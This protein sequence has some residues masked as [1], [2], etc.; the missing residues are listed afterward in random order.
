[1]R[2][3]LNRKWIMSNN[4]CPRCKSP[5]I[6]TFEMA[7]LS[8]VSVNSTVGAGVVGDGI[9]VGAASGTS[10]TLLAQS[11]APPKEKSAI[12]FPLLIAWWIFGFLIV[13]ENEK[14]GGL[15][16]ATFIGLVVGPFAPFMT[17]K[18]LISFYW[19]AVIGIVLGGL[20]CFFA[21][22]WN[23]KHFP[24]LMRQ[25][26]SSWLCRRCGNKW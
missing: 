17:L 19:A 8:G 25:W 7:Y 6:Q 13:W 12:L 3:P 10:E 16:S 18:P 2:V 14:E 15:F 4:Q 5:E 22:R 23:T 20:K 9:G 21:Y 11:I 26:K 1:M 24:D